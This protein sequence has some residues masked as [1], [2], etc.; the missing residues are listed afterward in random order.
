ME[1]QNDRLPTIA[2][3]SVVYARENDVHVILSLG[4]MPRQHASLFLFA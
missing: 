1:A 4:K 2:A 3:G